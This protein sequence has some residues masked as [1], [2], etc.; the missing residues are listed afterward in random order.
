VGQG[1][2]RRDKVG[3]GGTRW[4]KVGQD[5]VFFSDTKGGKNMGSVYLKTQKVGQ[6]GTRWDS[7]YL[8]TQKVGQDGTSWKSGCAFLLQGENGTTRDKKEGVKLCRK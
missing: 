4:D 8:K 1:G 6:G 5:G 3:Q 2:T 7:V